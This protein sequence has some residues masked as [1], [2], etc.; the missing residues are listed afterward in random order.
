MGVAGEI[1][2][3]A[4]SSSLKVEIADG[5]VIK[6]EIADVDLSG[7]GWRSESAGAFD[8]KI[9]AAFDGQTIGV[10]LTDVGEVEIVCG[11]IETESAS[12]ESKSGAAL[13]NGIVVQEADVVEGDLALAELK[14]RIELL[15][16]F[17]VGRGVVEMNR[18][19]AARIGEGSGSFQRNVGLAGDGIVDSR[20]GL[21]VREVGVEDVG[22]NVEI[23]VTGKVAVLE[24]RAGVKFGGGIVAGE[25]GVAQ[26][27]GVEGKL[28]CAGERIPVSVKGMIAGGGGKVEIKI[29]A[30]QRS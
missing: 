1:K 9:G 26:G 25:S 5:F 27:D 15:N 28:E 6:R 30:G 22:A 20:E 11:E 29:V 7:D 2:L 18:S 23:A 17:A 4:L 10:K 16:G 13:G 12:R 21:Q 3:V 8:H 14:S 24:C 19:V